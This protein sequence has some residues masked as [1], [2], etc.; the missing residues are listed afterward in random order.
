M[1]KHQRSVIAPWTRL[2]EFGDRG[3]SLGG[4]SNNQHWALRS[5]YLSK[6]TEIILML[7]L[8]SKRLRR[9]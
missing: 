7:K 2:V 5:K 1:G 8:E 6:A 4:I 3:E 9:Q